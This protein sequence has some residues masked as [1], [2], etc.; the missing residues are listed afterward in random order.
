MK[1][2]IK[3]IIDKIEYF[4][5]CSDFLNA[6][7]VTILSL[8][9]AVLPALVVIIFN[10]FLKKQILESISFAVAMSFIYSLIV[11][12]FIGTIKKNTYGMVHKGL[13]VILSILILV[14]MVVAILL[15]CPLYSEINKNSL[16][17]YTFSISLLFAF[18]LLFY[19]SYQ[20]EKDSIGDIFNTNDSKKQDKIKM[21]SDNLKTK[22]TK[23][24]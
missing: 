6:L 4:K 2:M 15:N 20:D 1:L 11:P 16:P 18:F 12:G 23:N 3:C 5:E 13:H 8:F 7:F 9:F 19:S 10:L 24:G 17:L 14:F 21:F 22:E